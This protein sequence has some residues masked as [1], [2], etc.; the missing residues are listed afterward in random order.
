MQTQDGEQLGGG[1][2]FDGQPESVSPA[3]VKP[4]SI[5]VDGLLAALD[6][7]RVVEALGRRV[8]SVKDKRFA[9]QDKTM[10]D[11]QQK[12]ARLEQL[13]SGSK[14]PRDQAMWFM[15]M[16]DRVNELVTQKTTQPTP[17]NPEAGT[18]GKA[19]NLDMDEFLKAAGI[20]P[21]DPDVPTVFDGGKINPQRLAG[22]VTRRATSPAPKVAQA[23]PTGTGSAQRVLD[24]D[25]LAAKYLE[26]S[27]EPTKNRQALAELSKQL[28]EL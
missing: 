17:S 12:L 25:E 15:E 20:D 1:A 6:D 3:S 11:F 18:Q 8:Q 26:L 9:N 28:K 22:L 13:M 14:M 2:G 4:T 23:M 24:K 7:P 16:E 19:A 21:N 10:S 5:D 27:R